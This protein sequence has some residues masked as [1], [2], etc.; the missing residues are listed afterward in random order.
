MI[1]C[2][3]FI[4]AYSELFTYI[5][6]HYG[7]PEVERFWTYLFKPDGKG[8]PLI[9]F[10][11]KNGL[12]GCFEYWAG[13]LK[14]EAADY[15]CYFNEKQGWL[16]SELVCPSKGR[17]LQLQKEIGLVPYYD[18]CAHCAYYRAALEKVGLKMIRNHIHVDEARCSRVLYD[19]K[20]MNGV[21]VMDQDTEILQY[22]SSNLA[23]LHRDFHSSMNMGVEFVGKEYGEQALIE[24]LQMYTKHY[25]VREIEAIRDRP[26][27]V[28]AGMIRTTYEKEQASDVLHIAE[29]ETSLVVRI[30]FCPAVKHLHDTGRIVSKWFPYTTSAVMQTMADVANLTFSMDAYDEETGAAKYSFRKKN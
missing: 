11:K 25:Y 17:L 13:T 18:Y 30:D 27:G 22:K 3:D 19:P 15:L 29:D 6:D 12:R 5:D 9:N 28:I 16:Y 8:I 10:A 1:S 20:K 21:M 7:K 4:V 24:Y 14:E 2:A 23:Y 26:F